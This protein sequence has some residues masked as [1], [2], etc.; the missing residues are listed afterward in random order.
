MTASPSLRAVIVS[1]GFLML[2]APARADIDLSGHWFDRNLATG[3][4]E[5]VQTGTAV[6][7]AWPGGSPAFTGTFDQ[8]RVDAT[9]SSGTLQLTPASDAS[10]LQGATWLW[11]LSPSPVVL[12]RCECYD[13]NSNDDDGCSSDCRIEECYTCTGDPSVC[14]PS[15][16]AAPCNDRNDCTTGETC[17][18]GTCGSGAAVSPCIDVSGQ[19]RFTADDYDAQFGP[20]RGWSA[21]YLFV[22]ENGNLLF[23]EEGSSGSGMPTGFGTIDP[24]SGSMSYRFL[25]GPL[26]TASRFAGAAADDAQSFSGT[27]VYVRMGYHLFCYE[28]EGAGSATRCDATLGCDLTDCTGHAD[29]TPCDDGDICTNREACRD[30]EC[31]ARASCS[32][33]ATCDSN[34]VC[35][36]DEGPNPSCLASASDSSSQIM[37]KAGR[38]YPQ[39]I[40]RWS[41]KRGTAT[42]IDDFA[43]AAGS[44]E[45]AI[46]LYNDLGELIYQHDLD[47]ETACLEPPCWTETSDRLTFKSKALSL[48]LRSGSDGRSSI[49]LKSN[50]ANFAPLGQ[51]LLPVTVPLHSQ[52]RIENGACFDASFDSTGV[53]RSDNGLFKAKGGLLP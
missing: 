51:Y 29:G 44:A 23:Y 13:T 26:C 1:T 24:G 43:D 53:S 31:M 5:I 32:I 42:S 20:E 15:A 19:W 50:D 9:G 18:A 3:P 21:D 2:A 14:I 6:T 10:Y 39:G 45:M 38:E 33:C 30:G 52:L 36:D 16:D 22:Q 4:V 17:T 34:G 11:P 25:T 37:L 47:R 40:V 48:K 27:F 35:Q 7:I 12:S 41:W 8:A 28:D 49:Q 46:C